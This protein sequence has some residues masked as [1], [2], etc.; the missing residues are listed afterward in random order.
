MV[1]VRLTVRLVVLVWKVVTVV[2]VPVPT[3]EVNV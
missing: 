1:V 2:W 3:L